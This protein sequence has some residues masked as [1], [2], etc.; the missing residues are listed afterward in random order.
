MDDVQ[1]EVLTASLNKRR[2]NEGYTQN[3]K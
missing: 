1:S 3:R 2:I